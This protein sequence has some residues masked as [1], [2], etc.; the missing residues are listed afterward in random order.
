M[1]KK[2]CIFFNK[3]FSFIL[4]EKKMKISFSTH[5]VSKKNSLKSKLHAFLILITFSF[6]VLNQFTYNNFIKSLGMKE[7]I[8]AS[9]VCSSPNE[10]VENRTSKQKLDF[11]EL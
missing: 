5:A 6:Y 11:P 9:I 1:W 7:T 10:F 4:N 8:C 2:I 3:Y